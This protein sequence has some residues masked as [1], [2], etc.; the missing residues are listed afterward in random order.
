MRKLLRNHPVRVTRLARMWLIAVVVAVAAPGSAYAQ[1]T[2]L[3]ERAKAR[4]AN[5]NGFIDRDEAGGR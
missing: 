3:S 5:G 4:D 2:E 1:G